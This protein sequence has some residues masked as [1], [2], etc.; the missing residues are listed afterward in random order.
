MDNLTFDTRIQQQVLSNA[1]KINLKF[2]NKTKRRLPFMLS[3]YII[4]LFG[5]ANKYRDFWINTF[6]NTE[7]KEGDIF[8]PKDS[9][10]AGGLNAEMLDGWFYALRQAVDVKPGLLL[11][12]DVEI[13]DQKDWTSTTV[14]KFVRQM[15]SVQPYVDNI[16]TFAYSH[17][18]SPNVTN[19]GFHDAYLYYLENGCI[20]DVPPAAPTD[21]R[22]RRLKNGDIS[23]TWRAP[24]DTS[25]ICGYLIIRDGAIIKKLQVP[26]GGTE[27][28][29]KT[30]FID[31]IKGRSLSSKYEVKSYDFFGNISENVRGK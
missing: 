31:N 3:P 24:S 27:N 8:S 20:K 7:L 11:W 1:K 16:I 22:K 30:S 23:L 17:Y 25:N 13:F 19:R 14:E 26:R 10:G 2:L 9:V 12:S 28:V 15:K 4:R 18:Y 6:N 5:N 21:I 29:L